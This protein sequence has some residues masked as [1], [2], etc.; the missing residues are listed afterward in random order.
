MRKQ[1][2]KKLTLAAAAALAVGMSAAAAEGPLPLPAHFVPVETDIDAC[3]NLPVTEYEPYWEFGNYWIDG[4]YTDAFGCYEDYNEQADSWLILPQL[5]T[6]AGGSFT[7]SYNAITRNYVT[8]SYTVCWGTEPTAEAMTNVIYTAEGFSTSGSSERI[9]QPF[10][11]AAGQNVYIGFHVNT[12]HGCGGVNLKVWD[13]TVS[14]AAADYPEQPG[15]SIA[16]DGLNGVATVEFPATTVGG[17]DITAEEMTATIVIDDK[18]SL[19][20]TA[21]GDA[22]AVVPVEFSVPAGQHT[23]VCTIS[24]EADG[25]TVYSKPVSQTFVA[26]LPDDFSLPLPLDFTPS[27]D[28]LSMMKIYDINEDGKTWQVMDTYPDELRIQENWKMAADDWAVLPAVEV[29]ETGKY[30]FTFRAAAQSANCPESVEFCLGTAPTPDAMKTVVL[31]L[32]NFTETR[33]DDSSLHL[34]EAECTIDKAGR[35]YIGIHAFSQKDMLTLSVGTITME[36]TPFDYLDPEVYAQLPEGMFELNVTEACQDGVRF[37]VKAQEQLMVYT[38][39]IFDERYITEDKLT[40]EAFAEQIL[41]ISNTALALFGSWDKAQEAEFFYFGDRNIE[42]AIVNPAGTRSFVAVMGLEYDEATNTVRPLTR[43]CRSEVF[44]YTDGSFSQE[45]A[46]A[47]MVDPVYI[48]SKG[49]KV[50]HVDIVLNATAEE[51][52][53][54]GF[55]PDHREHNSDS[56]IIQYLTSYSNMSETLIFPMHLEVA[57]EP[58]ERSLMCVATTD[59]NGRPSKRLNWMLVEAPAQTGQPVKV[60]ATATDSSGIGSVTVAGDGTCT[61]FDLQGRRIDSDRLTPGIYLRRSGS[62]TVKV[63]VR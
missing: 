47:D 33:N 48:E 45:E 43:L 18:E 37:S 3:V 54:K 49:K 55:A 41:K 28:A 8:V 62:E 57:L 23:A 10:D 52:Y 59:R 15:F 36:K 13:I 39:A 31:R 24:Y 16:M 27:A 56:E 51:A 44:E 53:G 11:I 12:E 46:W 32:E 42:N 2:T 1:F 50:V 21:T 4:D 35:Y 7:I 6:E 30:K 26:E 19:T 25:T 29:T 61:F 60:L 9:E 63:I 17:A 38:N 58:G 22:G 34:F 14:G 20:F 40:D 5:A